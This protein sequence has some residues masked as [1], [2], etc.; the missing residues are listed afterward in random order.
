MFTLYIGNKNYSSWSLRPWVLMKTLSIPF[1]ERLV[2]FEPKSSWDKFRDFSAS[3]LVPCLHD[4]DTVVWDSLAI[5]EYLAESHG[6]V[7]PMDRATRA[8]AR[9]VVSEM[10]SGF[11]ALRGECPMN[12]GL[13]VHLHTLSERLQK[14]LRR[15]DEI[16]TEGLVNHGGPYL[17]GPAFGAADAFYAP[18]AFR[19]RT[20]DLPLSQRS[21]DYAGRI[22][23]L[24][25]MREWYET[26]LREPWREQHH[27][28]E[29]AA[30]GTIL[31]DHR[32]D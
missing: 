15:I 29:I 32:V 10:H 19:A 23:Q 22:R 5:I 26:A 21:L 25:A 7:W 1:E 31:E 20:F 17:A 11:A 30:A 14:D 2:P 28:E 27:E 24:P 3:G 6:S 12:C 8:W 4:G 9:C 16:W 13:R 18:V